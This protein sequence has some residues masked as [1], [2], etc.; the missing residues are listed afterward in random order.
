[1]RINGED[2]VFSTLEA[3]KGKWMVHREDIVFRQGLNS[4]ILR[5]V[6]SLNLIG[7]VILPPHSCLSL[8]HIPFSF[9][10][11]VITLP[12]SPKVIFQENYTQ[13]KH[14][15]RKNSNKIINALKRIDFVEI[16]GA[17]PQASR[18]ATLPYYEIEA[19]DAAYTGTLIGPNRDLYQL[20]TEASGRLAVQIQGGISEKKKR[21]G[22]TREV[23]EREP[24]FSRTSHRR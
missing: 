3:S 14:L 20:P 16:D 6:N 13:I 23:K 8:L 22:E 24:C 1:V 5:S 10:F 12:K 19:E 9:S 7:L 21:C 4:V 18:G 15:I 2:Q 17:I 11:S